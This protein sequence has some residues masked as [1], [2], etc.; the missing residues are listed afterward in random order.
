MHDRIAEYRG[1]QEKE[2][3]EEKVDKGGN[4]NGERNDRTIDREKKELNG[5]GI[6]CME[7]ADIKNKS[8][9]LGSLLDQS[10]KY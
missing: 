3:S 7:T 5:Q 6:R 10:Q 9:G 8:S 4:L 1:Q 2:Y